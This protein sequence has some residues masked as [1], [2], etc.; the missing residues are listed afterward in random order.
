MI[1]PPSSR[2]ATGRASRR[3]QADGL[4]VSFEGRLLFGFDPIATLDLNASFDAS[5]DAKETV[6]LVLGQRAL[7]ER[8]RHHEI[9]H[10]LDLGLQ[11][12]VGEAVW[13]FRHAKTVRGSQTA[14]PANL[15]NSSLPGFSAATSTAMINTMHRASR[16]DTKT[17]R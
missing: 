5:F 6:Y 1:K 14:K 7:A 16:K 15:R 11:V 2:P 9:A 4:T 13:G 17:I 8:G 12:A 3:R 10:K